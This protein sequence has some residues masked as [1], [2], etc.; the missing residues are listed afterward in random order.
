[1]EKTGSSDT[2]VHIYQSAPNHITVASN[3]GQILFFRT[4]QML[5]S[6]CHTCPFVL[7]LRNLQ[8]VRKAYCYKDVLVHV[9]CVLSVWR[10]LFVMMTVFPYFAVMVNFVSRRD[11]NSFTHWNC[12]YNFLF[13]HT[14][15]IWIALFLFFWS[16]SAE[17]YECSRNYRQAGP[18]FT[19]KPQLVHSSDVCH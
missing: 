13:Q 15:S 5:N 2:S 12:I 9:K 11:W 7:Y 19:A 17:R 6:R 1:M 4:S 8:G 3:L 10:K 18:A 14:D 16:G